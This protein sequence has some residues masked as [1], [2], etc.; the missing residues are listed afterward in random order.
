MTLSVASEGPESPVLYQCT[1]TATTPGLTILANGRDLTACRETSTGWICRLPLTRRH[2]WSGR[3]SA[4]ST[5]LMSSENVRLSAQRFGQ[6]SV[7]WG[8]CLALKEGAAGRGTDRPAV[9][10]Q[11]VALPRMLSTWLWCSRQSKTAEAMTLSPRNSPHSPKPLL[12][13]RM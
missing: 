6:W 3:R 2:S 5:L 13:V 8:L 7:L 12:E 10:P 4:M 1:A 9:L 11:P